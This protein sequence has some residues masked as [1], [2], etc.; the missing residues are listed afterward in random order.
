MEDSNVYVDLGE[1]PEADLSAALRKRIREAR[2]CGMSPEG[3]QK[4]ESILKRF[5]TIFD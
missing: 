2:D 1:D 5:R 3:L 4:L